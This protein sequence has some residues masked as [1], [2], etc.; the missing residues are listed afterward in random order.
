MSGGVCSSCGALVEWA[1]TQSGGKMP[2]SMQTSLTGN[3]RV[4]DGVAIVGAPGSGDRISHFA[5]CP[6]AKIVQERDEAVRSKQFSA[7][8]YGQRFQRLRRWVN[9]EVK[10]LSEDVARRF[11]A[12]CANGAADPYEPH[13]W[14][15][16]IHGQTL[17][18]EQA[19]RERDAALAMLEALKKQI[20][21]DALERRANRERR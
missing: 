15:D 3:I 8:W 10:P 1:K 11:F 6:N 4:V 12:I 13:E 18:A 19:E 7:D 14:R 9:E 20:D 16:T 17:R 5:D 21:D 2:I